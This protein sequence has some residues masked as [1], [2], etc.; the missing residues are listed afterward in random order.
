M[1]PAQITSKN[2]KI[3]TDCDIYCKRIY[4]DRLSREFIMCEL[5]CQY[6]NGRRKQRR[7]R[8]KRSNYG[9]RSANYGQRSI[10]RRRKSLI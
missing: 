1:N 9:R 10:K 2:L 5:G 6:A 4:K 7:K 8:S 3:I